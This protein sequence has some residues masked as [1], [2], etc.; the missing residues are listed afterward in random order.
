MPKLPVHQPSVPDDIDNALIESVEAFL[1]EYF[2]DP[3]AEDAYKEQL[4]AERARMGDSL[5]LQEADFTVRGSRC[6]VRLEALR[7]WTMFRLGF[8]HK[9][10]AA[11]IEGSWSFDLQEL[12]KPRV[13][14]RRGSRQVWEEALDGFDEI[15]SGPLDASEDD[16]LSADYD[17]EDDDA[18]EDDDDELL[19]DLDPKE[20][21][22]AT[23]TD[24]ARVKAIAKRLARRADQPISVE[25]RQWL[26]DT[27]QA[28]PVITEALIAAANE[29][30][31]DHPMVAAYA[32][33]LTFELEY[34]R[35]RQDRGWEWASAML[36]DFQQRL[37]VFAREGG[38]PALFAAMGRSLSEARVRVSDEMQRALA[39]AGLNN[40]DLTPPGDLQ[41]A[42]R[43]MLSELAGQL[44]DPFEVVETLK[45][46]DAV[47][48]AELRAVLADIL[49]TA[50]QDMMREAAAILLLDASAEVRA[51]VVAALNEAMPARKISSTTLRRLI[52]IR[53]WW[54][55][56][57]R[58]PVD[59]LIRKV[60]LA[61]VEIEPWPKPLPDT[62]YHVSKIDGAGAQSILAI[63]RGASKGYFR[64]LLLR[65][66]EGIVDAWQEANLSRGKLTKM[67]RGTQEEM[68][69]VKM[70]RDYVDTMVQHAIGCSVAR[71]TVP[72]E[73][74]LQVAE[75]LN[76]SE[77]KARQHHDRL[78]VHEARRLFEAL[79]SADR[80]ESAIERNLAEARDSLTES[81]VLATWFEDGP[82]IRAALKGMASG[83]PDQLINVI[84]NEVVAENRGKWAERFVLMGMWCQAAPDAKQRRM[85]R[86]LITTA[87]ALVN[88]TP[89]TEIPAMTV[90]AVNT[91]AADADGSW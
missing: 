87:S 69:V 67:L 81:E 44:N 14:N 9:E 21:P 88:E 73:L 42:T 25:D 71:D 36:D 38:D 17:S 28:L 54:P 12:Q 86:G 23:S 78:R 66:G 82:K 77:W 18:D 57:E 10:F 11:T 22:P 47:M 33:M 62:D 31:L 85:A 74:F 20:P 43:S 83:K 41:E 35:Y 19:L 59:E 61:G 55:E 37:L 16:E 53:S 70:S 29:T 50:E 75:G 5:L 32:V 45:N 90:I 8:D 64:A 51:A 58:E 72:P 60:R 76:G 2:F 49:A 40:E 26:Q 6:N 52:A 65:H 3:D 39:D 89:L 80:T 68:P 27:P 91:L 46:M 63:S 13:T 15:W 1:S 7:T 84:V 79:P 24:R 4:S 56:A 34:V 48:P 30:G